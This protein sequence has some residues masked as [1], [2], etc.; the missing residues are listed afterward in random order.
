MIT[1]RHYRACL[2][3]RTDQKT[4]LQA[5][6]ELD[7]ST[8][9]EAIK[10]GKCLT[11]AI[12]QHKDMLFLYYESLMEDLKPEAL[13]KETSKELELWPEKDGKTPWAYM[14]NIYYHSIPESVDQWERN[15]KKKRR[16]RI[17]YLYPE[18]L[19]S[20]TYY[21]KAIVDEG[22]LDGDKYQSIAL[23]ENILFSYFEEPKSMTH[24]KKESK[25]ASKVIDEWIAKDPE[26][27]F[28]H[29]LSG[30]DNFLL[31]EEV[32]SMGKEDL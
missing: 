30:E 27:H 9:S 5:A 12:Y 4:M 20:Y 2:K 13:F 31:I 6:L 7:K 14:Y 10:G 23:H 17:A 28:D 8:V 24:I 16:G 32:F 25:E 26:S 1:R 18:K 15:S 22:L 29:T 19:F 21:H 11:V 3:P